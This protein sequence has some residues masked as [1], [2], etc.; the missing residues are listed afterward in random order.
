MSVTS[1]KDAYQSAHFQCKLDGDK[2]P[3]A[4]A[5]QTLVQV[6]REMHGWYNPA[7]TVMLNRS[8]GPDAK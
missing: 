3:S 2:V 4:R 1:V 6:W 7:A 8:A 5:I